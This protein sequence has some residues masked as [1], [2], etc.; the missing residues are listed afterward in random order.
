MTDS[1]YTSYCRRKLAASDDLEQQFWLHQLRQARSIREDMS[2][3]RQLIDPSHNKE[4][5]SH[6]LPQTE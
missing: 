4:E 1:S 2:Q 5:P 3:L 6:T